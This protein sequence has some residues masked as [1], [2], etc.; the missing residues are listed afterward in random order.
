MGLKDVMAWSNPLV[1]IFGVPIA[2]GVFVSAVF[3]GTYKS[4]KKICD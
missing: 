1:Y 3:H 4:L 2:V